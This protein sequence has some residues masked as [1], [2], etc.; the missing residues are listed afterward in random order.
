MKA[1]GGDGAYVVAAQNDPDQST[2]SNEGMEME[3]IRKEGNDVDSTSPQL[4]QVRRHSS[5]HKGRRA[6]ARTGTLSWEPCQ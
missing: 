3:A 6:H 5:D 4:D 1:R 2:P